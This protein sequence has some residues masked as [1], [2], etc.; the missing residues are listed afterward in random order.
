[1]H[2]LIDRRSERKILKGYKSYYRESHSLYF[3]SLPPL[4]FLPLSFLPFFPS[5]SFFSLF[6]SIKLELIWWKTKSGRFVPWVT[7]KLLTYLFTF[8]FHFS[9]DDLFPI[10]K[11]MFEK[12][13]R[14]YDILSGLE[15]PK[16]YNLLLHTD[17][18]DVKIV[19]TR[20]VNKIVSLFIYL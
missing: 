11:V 16:V 19:I 12:R 8:L 7:H 6:F 1:M 13:G 2:T 17:L 15:N 18:F 5:F 20:Y 10:L 3:S 9:W 4:S 14:S